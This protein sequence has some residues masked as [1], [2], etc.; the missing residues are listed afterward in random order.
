MM[1]RR[2]LITAC[3]A[4][5]SYGAASIILLEHF[6][7]SMAISQVYLRAIARR[8]RIAAGMKGC[9]GHVMSRPCGADV[10][11]MRLASRMPLTFY[12]RGCFWFNYG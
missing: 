10:G 6:A 2:K 9:M 5:L 11:D 1:V 3:V 4:M 7:F 12:G 8:S